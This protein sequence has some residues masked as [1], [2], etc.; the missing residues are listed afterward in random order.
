MVEGLLKGIPVSEG[1][2]IG[3][4][5][6]LDS[7]WDEV[8]GFSLKKNEI[9]EEVKRYERA[10]KEAAQQLIECRDRVHHE[11]GEEEAKI[12]EAHLAILKD[13]FFQEEVLQ[14]I[15]NDHKNAEFL[16]K[17]GI[18]RRSETFLQMKNEFFRYRMDDIRDVGVRLVRILLRTEEV[19]LPLK[20]PAVLVAHSLTPSDTARI[21]RDKVLG[22]ATE[23]GGPTSH[24]SILARSL[25]LP[26]V[27]GVEKLM[28]KARN[29]DSIIVD[30]NAGI[31]TI[32]PPQRLVKEYQRRQKQFDAYWKR[33][34]QDIALPAVTMDGVAISLQANIASTAD[35][36]MA[37]QY[38]ADGIGLFRTELPFL[39]AGRLLSE[40]E[41]FIIYRTVVEV[42]KGKTVIIRTLDL[43]GDKFLPFQGIEE[44]SN[45]FLGWRSIRISLQEKDVFMAQLRA[46]LRASHFGKV[47]ILFPMVSSIEEIVEIRQVLSKTEAELKKKGIPF[48]EAIRFGIMI[49]VPSAAIMSDRLAA[50]VDYFSIGT[51]DLIQY[52][53][54][55]DRNNE[56][57]ARFYQ[58]LNPS[59]LYLIHRT[60]QSAQEANKPVSLCGEMAG[61]PIYTPM[62]L[63]FGLRQFSMSPLMLPEVKE[64]VRAVSIKECEE[65]AD[66]IL[67]MSSAEEI[68]K[69]LWSF[70]RKINRRQSVPYIGRSTSSSGD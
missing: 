9:E 36:S 56:K 18:D 70:N 38:Q 61:N 6:V 65:V 13:P 15:K 41:Q 21:D 48:D 4:V 26:A 49:E 46:I 57:V 12:F 47:G 51:N 8:V 63:G 42:M 7:L 55:V 31:V 68:E 27:V 69:E 37:V 34:S 50:H 3:K 14:S 5:W 44:E 53:L 32:D 29:G 52:T 59:V 17:E 58:P 60:I 20:E 11:I 23:F 40:E 45:P 43:G 10:L 28:K 64:R 24:A 30:G 22:F 54:A 33:L 2:A 39:T 1:I 35:T 67:R 66:E 16:L 62:L 19:K 25:G